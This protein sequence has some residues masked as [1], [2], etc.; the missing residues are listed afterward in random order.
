MGSNSSQ[1]SYATPDDFILRVDVEIPGLLCRDDQTVATP[2][3][4]LADPVLQACLEDASGVVEAQC[5]IAGRY[6]PADLQGLTGVSQKFLKRIVCGLTIQYLRWRRGIMEPSTYPMYQEAMKWLDALSD[7]EAIFAL[8][9]V[10]RAGLPHTEA[11]TATDHYIL[12]PTLLTNNTRQ[13]GVR[14][15]Q[16]GVSGLTNHSF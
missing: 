13:W 14:S 16:R 12:T 7:G 10:E 4:L 11:I 3:A 15:N 2:A 9:Q 6:T 8:T 1:T 5:L